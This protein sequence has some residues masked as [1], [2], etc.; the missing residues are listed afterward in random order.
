M[1]DDVLSRQN[2]KNHYSSSESP[3]ILA[4]TTFNKTLNYLVS[5]HHQSQDGRF[6]E[7]TRQSMNRQMLTVMS[8]EFFEHNSFNLLY[9][10]NMQS[11]EVMKFDD[12]SFFKQ[13]FNVSYCLNEYDS[14][15]NVRIPLSLVNFYQQINGTFSL[16]PKRSLYNTKHLKE[17]E[18]LPVSL[19][20]QNHNIS[21]EDGM[22]LE[23]SSNV[24]F[25]LKICRLVHSQLR[26]LQPQKIQ[27]CV[28]IRYSM[29]IVCTQT[30][31]NQPKIQLINLKQ[32]DYKHFF[33]NN[34]QLMSSNQLYIQESNC[35]SHYNFDNTVNIIYNPQYQNSEIAYSKFVNNIQYWQQHRLIG[36]NQKVYI[37]IL[38]PRSFI[39]INFMF[40]DDQQTLYINQYGMFIAHPKQYSVLTPKFIVSQQNMLESTICQPQKMSRKLLRILFLHGFVKLY[41]RLE[42]GRYCIQNQMLNITEV[43]TITHNETLKFK[44]TQI[45]KTGI[46]KIEVIVGNINDLLKDS[47]LSQ[48]FN[49]VDDLNKYL[50]DVLIKRNDLKFQYNNVD[51]KFSDIYQWKQW[52]Q[53]TH[54]PVNIKLQQ[55]HYL[56]NSIVILSFV[57]W[58]IYLYN[59]N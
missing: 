51:Y 43:Q 3:L 38:K 50:D 47:T 22:L 11:S 17:V 46:Y 4:S 54:S 7:S 45:P 53:F 26:I 36:S 10:I 2:S 18:Y 35:V 1:I 9:E 19:F 24:A 37:D 56:I 6:Y 25:Y 34:V 52:V 21:L 28:N 58:L 42:G 12:C 41:Y 44:L 49:F 48:C 33:H 16:I 31:S 8:D 30:T 14:E 40:N 5:D 55:N 23:I 27:Q 13:R 20:L 59:Q 32:L 39:D 29:I 57:L 15:I